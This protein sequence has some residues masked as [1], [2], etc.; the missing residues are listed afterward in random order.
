MLL[1]TLDVRKNDVLIYSE[2]KFDFNKN[3]KIIFKSEKLRRPRPISY[4]DVCEFIKEPVPKN[5]IIYR[6]LTN[7]DDLDAYSTKYGY[8]IRIREQMELVYFDPVFAI[9]DLRHLRFELDPDEFRFKIQQVGL[10]SSSS[11]GSEANYKESYAF[12]MRA[13]EAQNQNDKIFADAIF[14]FD[15]NFIDKEDSENK[16]I[17]SEKY[18]VKERRNKLVETNG[19]SLTS[20]KNIEEDRRKAN[21]SMTKLELPESETTD[22]RDNSISLLKTALGIQEQGEKSELKSDADSERGKTLSN[23]LNKYKPD[24]STKVDEDDE[25]PDLLEL[26][27]SSSS[28]K[29]GR[30]REKESVILRFRRD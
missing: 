7:V 24:V 13:I 19:D 8:F 9:K 21:L 16:R 22:I 5:L 11:A 4:F 14:A 18:S 17:Y 6:L 30:E 2:N 27:K 26:F 12:D 3:F 15:R 23:F 10:S 28:K 29:V 20:L 1:E 25:S